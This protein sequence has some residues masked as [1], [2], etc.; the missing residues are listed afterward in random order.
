MCFGAIAELK[1][2]HF[3]DLIKYLWSFLFLIESLYLFYIFIKYLFIFLNQFYSVWSDI[4][5]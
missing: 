3:I 1:F 4:N 5:E 2:D